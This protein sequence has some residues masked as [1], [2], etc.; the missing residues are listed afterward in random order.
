MKFPTICNQGC[1]IQYITYDI[2]KEMKNK[3]LISVKYKK[4]NQK[5]GLYVADG[6]W[7]EE[8]AT[9]IYQGGR[10]GD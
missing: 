9:I 1:F 10:N 6:R 5:R 7:N 2:L 8:L 3:G 4:S